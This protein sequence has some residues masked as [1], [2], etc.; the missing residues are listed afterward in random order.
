VT[1]A[2]ALK[3]LTRLAVLAAA[4]AVLV[5]ASVPAV[6]ATARLCR[7]LE[8]ELGSVQRGGGRGTVQIRRYDKAITEQQRQL[9]IARDRARAGNCSSSFFGG[10]QCR[11]FR[12]KLKSMERNLDTLQRQRS[13]LAGGGG[14]G[15]SR[16]RILA[17]LDANGCRGEQPVEA[18]RPRDERALF[19]RL[20]GGGIREQQPL[21][22]DGVNILRPNRERTQPD[23]SITFAAPPGE[24][25][26][27]C[28]R[29]CD[30]Y[31]FPMSNS[32]SPVDFD[33]DRK[34]CETS[35][36]GATVDLYYHR[37]AGEESESMISTV[38]GD[39]YTALP[40]AYLYKRPDVPSPA[41]CTCGRQSNFKVT[42]GNGPA[43]SLPMAGSF[44]LPEATPTVAKAK[45]APAPVAS[46]VDADK[47]VRVVGPE[48][49]PDPSAAI[50]LRA[51]VPTQ[52]R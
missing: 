40:T 22:N 10:G 42:A 34:N 5:S 2:A 7:Q 35:C 12:A 44:V 32:S 49:L 52:V 11:A 50:D 28:V 38:S 18:R 15:R 26:T 24:Y 45:E 43:A 3:A 39:P 16:S 19:T 4:G 30:G 47:P 29:T 51:P 37:A 31:F 17:A 48:F 33:R 41:G 13:E 21:P 1:L 46:Q 27:L 20:F 6:S 14:S 8:A 25:R 23:G 36:A 9:G